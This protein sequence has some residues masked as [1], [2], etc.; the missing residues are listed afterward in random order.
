MGSAGEPD[1]G[2]RIRDADS[3]S[4][5]S[6]LASLLARRLLSSI[7][8][9]VIVSFAVFLLISLVPGD[10]AVTLA[11]GAN[12]TPEAIEQVRSD[13]H[14]DD[15][16]IVQYG[17][18]VWG[19]FHLDLGSSIVSGEAVWDEITRRFP[20]TLGLVIASSI[21]AILIGVPLGLASGIWPGSTIDSISRF[22]ASLGLAVPSFWLALI[23][24]S[25][26]A[27]SW[28]WLPPSGYVP[29]SSSVTDWL[30]HIVLPA[31]ALGFVVAASIARQLR[32]ALIDVLSSNYI[33][34][35]WAKGASPWGVILRHALKNAAMPALTIFGIQIGHLLGGAVIIEIIFS[36]PG[37]GT[38][39]FTALINH[40]L[41]VVQ[42]V[43]LVL[44]FAQVVMS[45]VVDVCYGFLNP[46]IRVS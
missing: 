29:L 33:R 45:L 25:I 42:G 32:G 10:A 12:A 2:L 6:G 23:L 16:I 7:P 4:V 39:F 17:R 40:D 18:W 38:Y 19:L 24:V 43:V 27:V 46:K 30:Q 3:R 35:A 8:I 9:L 15:P 14:L 34:T 26:F 44:V 13:L 5:M 21:V 31:V 28:G 11:G 41:P 36:L 37:L 1:H 20:V 22:V